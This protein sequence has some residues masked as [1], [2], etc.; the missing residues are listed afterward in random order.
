MELQWR[1]DALDQ[2]PG[3]GVTSG[4]LLR[5][6]ERRTDRNHALHA[7]Q[8]ETVREIRDM[9][10]SR[11]KLGTNISRLSR[12]RPASRVRL[13]SRAASGMVDQH[14][15]RQKRQTSVPTPESKPPQGGCHF[16]GG[17]LL[18]VPKR[19]QVLAVDRK[20]QQAAS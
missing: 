3:A 7:D 18:L 8:K 5:A 13:A 9:T 1:Q 2:R 16:I 20:Q 6:V 11:P 14:P 17:L 4:A 15:R 19:R 10:S 12:N